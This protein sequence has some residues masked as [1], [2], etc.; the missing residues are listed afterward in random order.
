[1][2][3]DIAYFGWCVWMCCYV[4]RFVVFFGW[5]LFLFCLYFITLCLVFN[6]SY[7]YL[8]FLCCLL[9]DELVVCWINLLLSL[10]SMVF[11]VGLMVV[12]A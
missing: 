4:Y 3:V 1:M 11:E 10:G 6:S 9:L 2:G 5:L 8:L 7:V 12:I